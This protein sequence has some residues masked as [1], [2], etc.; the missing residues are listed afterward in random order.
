M[1]PQA[2]CRK[3]LS[4]FNFLWTEYVIF[5]TSTSQVLTL[6]PK[7]K[8]HDPETR[9]PLVLDTVMGKLSEVK[10]FGVDYDT[11]DSM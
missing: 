5:D 1:G 7:S 6:N 11:K 4:I 2:Y 10:I 8:Y 9:D 3:L